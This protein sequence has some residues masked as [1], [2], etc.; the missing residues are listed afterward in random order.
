MLLFFCSNLALSDEM[1]DMDKNC[2]DKLMA[3]KEILIENK[4]TFELMKKGIFP[5]EEI[6]EKI[7]NTF[8]KFDDIRIICVMRQSVYG[9]EWAIKNSVYSTVSRSLGTIDSMLNIIRKHQSIPP[10]MVKYLNE[11]RTEALNLL[12]RKMDKPQS[13]NLYNLDYWNT[14]RLVTA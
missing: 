1:L 5:S 9:R 12:E 14:M 8:N 4:D 2:D 3:V 6:I 7:R 10:K 13:N 11:K